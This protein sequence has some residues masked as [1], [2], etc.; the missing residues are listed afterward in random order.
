MKKKVLLSAMALMAL[1]AVGCGKQRNCECV[2]EDLVTNYN[3]ILVVDHGIDCGDITE[4]AI[5][6]KYVTEDGTH[7]LR[8]EV[9]KVSCHE[10]RQ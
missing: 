10:Q 1:L 3:P 7:S 5:E 6:E 4:M 9:H 2:V 8:R